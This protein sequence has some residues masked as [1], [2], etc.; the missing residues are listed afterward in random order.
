MVMRYGGSSASSP[1]EAEGGEREA[2]LWERLDEG[3][4]QCNLCHH[5]CIIKPGADGICGVRRNVDGKLHTLIY[6]LASSVNVDPIEKKPLFHYYPGTLSYS[7]GTVGCNFRCANCQNYIISQATMGQFSLQKIP[8]E[9]A[10]DNALSMG[11]TSMSWTYNE[12]TIWFEYTYDC[13]KLAHK[14][15]LKTVYVTNGYI[16]PE[17]LNEIS[18]YL[19]VFRVDIKGKEK[20]YQEL[21]KARLEGV[22]ES[23]ISAFELGMHIEIVNLVIPHYNDLDTDIQWLARWV[24]DNLGP[25]VPIHFTR[26]YPYYNLQDVPLTP[27]ATLERAH[28]IAREAGVEYPYIG[29]VSGHPYENTYCPHCGE[30]LIERVGYNVHSRIQNSKCPACG[31]PIPIV[32]IEDK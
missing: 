4:V 25:E 6:G 13:A 14:R 8:P 11:C 24:V 7:M 19:D 12:P 27:V 32:G 28:D 3:K 2:M 23:T 21:A 22:L 17:A 9:L 5:R 31:H 1:V 20:V 15:G 10:V 26:F 18:P 30:L 16:T 29:N